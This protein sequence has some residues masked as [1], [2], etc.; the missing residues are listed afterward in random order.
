MTRLGVWNI[1]ANFKVVVR[2]LP[3]KHRSQGKNM[4]TGSH[5]LRPAVK[6]KPSHVV[7]KVIHLREAGVCLG[8][9]LR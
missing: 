2:H 6:H 4:T 8:S 5:R 9:P 7:R 1:K 3:K